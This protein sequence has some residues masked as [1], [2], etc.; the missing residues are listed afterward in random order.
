[1]NKG[2]KYFPKEG[3]VGKLGLQ[4]GEET[5]ESDNTEVY[6]DLGE[7]GWVCLFWY[8]SR[9]KQMKP[10]SEKMKTSD[11]SCSGLLICGSFCSGCGGL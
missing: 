6:K 11:S 7:P 3:R 10:G 8:G 1:M 9:E 5:V 4:S 2:I